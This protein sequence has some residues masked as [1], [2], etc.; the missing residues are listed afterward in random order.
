MAALRRL[1]LT[2]LVQL[3][4][5]DHGSTCAC[6]SLSLY[7][8]ALWMHFFISI[9]RAVKIKT[10]NWCIEIDDVIHIIGICS[11]TVEYVSVVHETSTHRSTHR[12]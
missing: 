1:R 3:D 9:Y 5:A 4:T 12:G 7:D 10:L 2:D 6:A 11:N 8:H